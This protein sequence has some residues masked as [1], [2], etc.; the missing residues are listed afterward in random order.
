MLCGNS[1]EESLPLHAWGGPRTEQYELRHLCAVSERVP[2]P[3]QEGLLWMHQL[4]KKV[5]GLPILV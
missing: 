2:C 4:K 5:M 1:H 3:L